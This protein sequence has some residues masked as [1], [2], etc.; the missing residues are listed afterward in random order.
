MSKNKRY[1]YYDYSPEEQKVMN[2]LYEGFFKEKFQ[3]A[4]IPFVSKEIDDNQ[5]LK[6]TITSL[7]GNTA[8]A[9]TPVGQTI[10]IDVPK[11]EKSVAKLGFPAIKLEKGMTLDVIVFKDKGGNYTGSVS[12]G[13]EAALKKELMEAIKKET[14]A[15]R[16]KIE[17]TCPGGFM[18]DLS[19]I[20]CFLPGSLAAANRILDFSSYIGKEMFVMLEMFD[21]KRN[22]FVVSFKKYLRK[23]IDSKVEELSLTEKYTGTVTGCS[24]AGVFVEWNEYYT[25][26]IPA[27]EFEGFDPNRSF[28]GGE[29]VSFY[30]TDLKNSQ[31]IVLSVKEPDAKTRDLQ[32]LKDVSLLEEKENKIYMGTVTKVKGFGVFVKLDNGL[33]GLI[34]KERLAKPAKEYKIGEPISCTI[35]DVEMQTSKLHLKESIETT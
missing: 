15:Y 5:M 1:T 2:S 12:A 7:Q 24:S 13:Y 4:G 9:E 28:N 6:V 23:I 33:I 8:V 25:G 19:G 21:E 30:V 32:E 3:D 29:S 16:I 10:L 18:V 17:N 31:R 35:L 27:E 11:E 14:T 26:L 22:I 20:K 34:E